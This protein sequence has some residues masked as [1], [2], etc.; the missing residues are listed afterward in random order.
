MN[1][2]SPQ[3]DR[4]KPN[5]GSAASIPHADKWVGGAPLRATAIRPG[6]G[7]GEG[8]A[9][10]R[11][12]LTDESTR[13]VLA[14]VLLASGPMYGDAADL[15]AWL[16]TAA[17][18]VLSFFTSGAPDADISP[19]GAW[20]GVVSIDR[21]DQRRVEAVATVGYA[22]FSPE[23]VTDI[24]SGV[25]VHPA[26]W[27]MP[28][29]SSGQASLALAARSRV[30]VQGHPADEAARVV[31]PLGRFIRCAT[32][33][34]DGN[35]RRALFWQVDGRAGAWVPGAID[36]AAAELLASGVSLAFSSSWLRREQHRRSLVASL[37]V[38]QQPILPLL[39]SGLSQRQIADRIGRSLHTVHDHVKGIYAT[40]GVRSRFA[41]FVLWNGG[42]V[43]QIDSDE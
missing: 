38:S 34:G 31:T 20:A 42:D 12:A 43:S 22:G 25:C 1:G 19:V 10:N 28:T 26:N 30:T 18:N 7:A 3:S 32:S 4:P 14:R 11:T 6:S 33:V 21:L 23:Q 24:A 13:E 17:R 40:L 36:S 27:P 2:S 35:A 29:L 41:L 9:V 15:D 39:A 16:A 5:T 37:S 8:A